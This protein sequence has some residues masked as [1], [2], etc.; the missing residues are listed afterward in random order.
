[1]LGVINNREPP[2]LVQIL[3]LLDIDVKITMINVF[4]KLD[5]KLENFIRN[6]NSIL[7]KNQIQIL[8]E[9]FGHQN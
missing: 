9:K 2:T 4:K 1:M 3:E 8:N 7:K 6:F 5:N